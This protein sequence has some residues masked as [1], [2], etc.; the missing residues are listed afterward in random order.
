MGQTIQIKRSSSND[1]PSSALAEGELAYGHFGNS[2]GKLVIGRP[3]SAGGTATNDVIGGKVF[4]DAVNNATS[5]GTNNTIVKR[6][7]T[8]GFTAG[9]II[10]TGFLGN[11]TGDIK[12]SNGTIIFNNGSNSVAATFTGNVTGDVTGNVTGDVKATDGTVVLNNGTDGTDATFTGAVT[13][14]VSGSSSSCTGTAATATALATERNINGVGFDGTGDITL[15]ADDIAE[16]SSNPTNLY[17]TDTRA[18]LTAKAAL[19]HS[20]H[21]NMS[22][23]FEDNNRK[24]IG[25]GT[26]PLAGGS[27]VTV[28]NDEISIGQSVAPQATPNFARLGIG[29]T[30][31]STLLLDVDGNSRVNGNLTV[32]GT[33][34]VEDLI[35][36]GGTNSTMLIKGSTVAGI[37]LREV[38]AVTDEIEAGFTTA[39]G[40]T[41]YFVQTTGS[42]GGGLVLQSSFDDATLG[43][44]G[45]GVSDRQL[46]VHGDTQ[47]LGSLDFVGSSSGA[48]EGITF[49][50]STTAKEFKIK[51]DQSNNILSI[52]D[53]TT[54]VITI[55]DA[56]NNNPNVTISRDTDF[57]GDVSVGGVLTVTGTQTTITSTQLAVGDNVITLNDDHSDDTAADE[58]AGIEINRG[59]ITDSSDA[60][61]K[62]ELVF[63]ASELEWVVKVPASADTATQNASTPVLTVANIASKSYVIDG[64]SF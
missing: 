29:K 32:T 24:I 46:K 50:N 48:D 55:P 39:V 58:D 53:G 9:N 41:N 22:F 8:G 26:S 11:L 47:I 44:G 49:G 1:V 35:F 19:D 57:T 27:G 43:V 42:G 20:D 33:A 51:H 40:Q 23:T 63:D 25:S 10:S 54:P 34:T 45:A 31:D 5:L 56:N 7:S 62:A 6:S 4:V 2:A 13:G 52:D 37:L 12:N 16:A 61:A 18:Y 59:L 30:A 17:F 28:S 64:G 36:D 3:L 21:S 60:R 38:H 14:N 15:D